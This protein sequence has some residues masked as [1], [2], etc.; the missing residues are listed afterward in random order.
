[1]TGLGTR[2]AALMT[3]LML[4]GLAVA[5]AR[6]SS[7]VEA[8]GLVCQ[9][10]PVSVSA[11]DAHTAL[12]GCEAAVSAAAF[13]SAIGLDPAVSFRLAIVDRPP[14]GAGLQ[15]LGC[16]HR[17]ENKAWVPVVS[18]CKAP[19]ASFGLTMNAAL[20]RSLSVHEVAHAIAAHHFR[21][22]RAGVAAQEYIAYVTQ[23]ATMPAGLRELVLSRYPPA[24]DESPGH[25]NSYVYMM[26]PGRF[27]AIAWRHHEGRQGGPAFIRAE[28]EGRAL[29]RNE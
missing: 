2:L 22:A 15:A 8:T 9:T 11:P 13:F 7:Q 17:T 1:M 28:L 16:Y 6:G 23:F 27:A 21:V 18:A 29:P 20:H 5:P 10:V 25:L 3:A 14:E 4:G 19:E 26:D 12:I 24:P